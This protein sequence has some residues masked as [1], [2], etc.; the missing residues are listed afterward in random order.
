ML[1]H[2]GGWTGVNPAAFKSELATA[3]IFQRLGYLTVTVDYRAGGAG[4]ADLEHYYDVIRRRYGTELP[5]CAIG[6][7]AGGNL[8][9]LLAAHRPRMACVISLAGPTDLVALR[10][11]PGGERAYQ[12]ALHAFG[13]NNLPRYSPVRYAQSIRARV[14]LLYASNDPIVPV[15][16]GMLMARADRHSSLIVLP[17]GGTPF[18]HS[19]VNTAAAHRAELSEVGFLARSTSSRQ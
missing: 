18:V 11:E 19:R 5:V 10:I 6:V 14:M 8:A 3:P 17:P 13:E 15:R 12:L 2:G 1:I 4:L 7:S 16:Q 9:L